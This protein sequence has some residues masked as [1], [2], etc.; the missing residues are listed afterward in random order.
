MT[1][2]TSSWKRCSS[3]SL[4]DL[5]LSS[6]FIVPGP[7]CSNLIV[8]KG[9]ALR[10][11]AH[12]VHLEFGDKAI[13]C[14]MI[15][16]RSKGFDV[17][18]RRGLR[19]VETSGVSRKGGLTQGLCPYSAEEMGQEQRRPAGPYDCP[20]GMRASRSTTRPRRRDSN[21]RRARPPSRSSRDT[22]RSPITRTLRLKQSPDQPSRNRKQR[23]EEHTS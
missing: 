8:I 16:L 1:P 22:K 7:T 15:T 18:L 4:R 3:L 12:A 9:N 14:L 17:D 20:P 19:A 11:A 2:V 5:P 13:G 6:A 23:S 21:A 10:K